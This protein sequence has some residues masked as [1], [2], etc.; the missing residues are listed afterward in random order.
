MGFRKI[1]RG[2]HLSIDDPWVGVGQMVRS[3]PTGKLEPFSKKKEKKKKN[4]P[5]LV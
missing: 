1:Q 5:F 3:P 4:A 2:R